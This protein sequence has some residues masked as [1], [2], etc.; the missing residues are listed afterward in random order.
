[1]KCGTYFKKFFACGCAVL[2]MLGFL[3][4]PSAAGAQGLVI[5]RALALGSEGSDV[6]SLQKFLK[7]EGFYTYSAITGYFGTITAEAVS[8]FQRANG[9]SP[10]GTVGPVTRAALALI[11]DPASGSASV[12]SSA[13]TNDTAVS[14]LVLT[15]NLGIGSTGAAVTS[16]QEFLQKLGFYTYSSITGYFGSITAA[17]VSAYQIAHGITPVG[18]VGPI[19]RAALAVASAPITTTT[20]TTTTTPTP[21]T[22]PVFSGGG[23][24]GGDVAA[25]NNFGG[26]ESS[27][28]GTSLAPAP[29]IS[30][31][32]STSTQTTA[33]I[34]WTTDESATSQVS[35]GPSST[36]ASS[37]TLDSS[38]VT[39]HS[40]IL[41][42]LTASS[43]YHY[44]VSSSNSEGTN[45]VS[46]DGTFSTTQSP[47]VTP[48]VISAISSGTPG[49]T[50]ATILW[51]TNEVANS[52]IDYGLTTSY[53]SIATSTAYT[54][55][56]SLIAG[57]LN[58]STLYHYEIKS[59]DPSGNVAT[60]LDHTFTTSSVPDTT[61]PIVALTSPTNGAT[62]EGTVTLSAS[63][64]DNVAVAGVTFRVNGV[65]IGSEDT[66][67][68]YSISWNTTATSSG[69]YSIVAVARDTSNNFA[70]STPVTVT[71]DNSAGPTIS[72]ISY[73]YP[74]DT[75]ATI[76]WTTNK[77]ANS[78]VLYGL[79][80][81]YGLSSMSAQYVTS[82]S[83]TLYGLT[84]STTYH[85]QIN[86]S[87]AAGNVASS[88]DQSFTT[89]PTLSP[90]V[91]VFGDSRTANGGGLGP[92]TNSSSYTSS[93]AISNDFSACIPVESNNNT[94]FGPEWN[95]GVGAQSTAGMVSRYSTASTAT[96]GGTAS[97]YVGAGGAITVTDNEFNIA[98]NAE[99]SSLT[100]PSNVIVFMGGVNDSNI[101]PA[102]PPQQQSM[103]NI[104]TLLTAWRAAGK[105]VFLSNELPTGVAIAYREQYT[106][107]A[108]GGTFTVA[109]ASSFYNDG[110]VSYAPAPGGAND[111]V[112]LTKVSSAPGA[113]QYSVASG[114]YTFSAAD[115]GA[116]V[117]VDYT[118]I[119]N[120]HG[121]V[122]NMALHNWLTSSAADFVDPTSGI[123]YQ[124]P[125]ALYN[126]S[127]VIPV[128][129]WDTIADPA[130]TALSYNLP[131][132]LFDGLHPTLYGCQ[133]I[134]KPISAA[135]DARLPST[136]Y[137]SLP[138]GD[139]E[140]L[141]TSNGV[142]TTYSSADTSPAGKPF[143]L[144]PIIPGTFTLTAGTTTGTDDGNGNIVGAG[145]ASSTI[146]YATGSWVVNYTSKPPINTKIIGSNE[147]DGDILFNGSFSPTEGFTAPTTISGCSAGCQSSGNITSSN[148][149]GIPAR[150]ISTIDANTSAQIASGSMKINIALSTTTSDGYPEIELQL[151]GKTSSAGSMSITLTQPGINYLMGNQKY[152]G[153]AVVKIDAGPNG[154]LYGLSV[155]QA[156]A[157]CTAGLGTSFT[158]AGETTTFSNGA[159]SPNYV[160]RTGTGGTG[161]EFSDSDISSGELRL[162]FLTQSCDTTGM[163][164]S[165]TGTYLFAIA[166]DA[167]TP[168]S[169]TIHISRASMKPYSY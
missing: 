20:T 102:S 164:G 44:Q 156:K 121:G 82:H 167:S 130:Q 154:H 126:R 91:L 89:T 87:D 105:V 108:G 23:G 24:G 65:T 1:M 162:P 9:I 61:P 118:Y 119:N 79:T 131:Y 120:A 153:T 27:G 98:S 110:Y 78:T 22:T 84:A 116:T 114:Q 132:T 64:S 111:G 19:T 71:V 41:T 13:S 160:G 49:Q 14:G 30:A 139:T 58:A 34:T 137:S 39:S 109:H 53:G 2:F 56:H 32:T 155:V 36:Y 113:G 129:T 151:S 100:D 15:Q 4:I 101:G 103:I 73:G 112:E 115:A 37:T 97:N 17:A 81:S 21:G 46:S 106:I 54:T 80:T 6:T 92:H 143:E 35:Y 43:T 141:E 149:T 45:S 88:S 25:S 55:S 47:D 90:Q 134:A 72:A 123:D 140:L 107:P 76:T 75:S 150:W 60:S 10:V 135:I 86:S 95:F 138:T 57:G 8:A 7:A 94:Y 12:S 96:T 63:S 159:S 62:I 48:P 145:I 85:F 67:G 142:K 136:D 117:A 77:A 127:W 93:I 68:P 52:E 70:T 16:L 146:N 74:T 40:V 122:G 11:D 28:G 104:A 125:G 59:T 26:G 158:P 69:S 29:V 163:T 124:I 152:R 168:I 5:T 38:L 51:T 161:L 148:N 99:Y 83:Q 144:T 31:V 165:L 18:S 133:Q 147:S 33:T 157:T 169:A 42:G 128:D 66:S 3:C 50:S 166:A